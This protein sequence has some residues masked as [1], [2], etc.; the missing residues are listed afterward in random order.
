MLRMLSFLPPLGFYILA[1]CILAATYSMHTSMLDAN[2]DADVNKVWLIG[3][4][5]AFLLGFGGVQQTLENREEAKQPRV[6]S[7]DVLQ[8]LTPTTT[9]IADP[10]LDLPPDMANG[11]A[12]DSPLGRVRAKSRAES[13]P[14]ANTAR[15]LPV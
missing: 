15:D 7:L 1:I 2:P 10:E 8:K 5:L 4:I 6:S 11:P 14:Q 12:D 13:E 3:G 9:G